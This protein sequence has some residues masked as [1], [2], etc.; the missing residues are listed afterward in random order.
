VGVWEDKKPS[1][2]PKQDPGGDGAVYLRSMVSSVLSSL[3]RH[4]ALTVSGAVSRSL[5][6]EGAAHAG[7]EGGA[8]RDEARR[9]QQQARLVRPLPKFQPPSSR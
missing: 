2:F 5:R 1:G 8:L 6:P 9:P 7:G 3:I 4:G